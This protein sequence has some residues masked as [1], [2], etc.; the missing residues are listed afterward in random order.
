[1][2]DYEKFMPKQDAEEIKAEEI[3]AE[4]AA[5]D[6]KVTWNGTPDSL[7]LPPMPQ[8]QNPF[9]AEFIAAANDTGE[10]MSKW[11]YDHCEENAL[12]RKNFNGMGIALYIIV[13][14]NLVA[15][16]AFSTTDI[17]VAISQIVISAVFLGLS[18]GIHLGRSRVCAIIYMVIAVINSILS[19][20]S[21]SG[22]SGWIILWAGIMACSYTFSY[23]SRYKE[24]M[25]TGI[26]RPYVPTRGRNPKNPNTPS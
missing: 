18:L 25:K 3:K 15:G 4:E 14:I 8:E 13:G 9:N 16:L 24:Y 20:V 19:I 22:A 1:M 2:M 11:E 26:L 21:G 7:E 12:L 17:G 23:A 6:S 5:G 10:R